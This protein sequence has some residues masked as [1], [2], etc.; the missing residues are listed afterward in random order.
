MKRILKNILDIFNRNKSKYIVGV[1]I[2]IS[3]WYEECWEEFEQT[4]NL[5]KSLD[6]FFSVAQYFKNNK[7]FY[8]IETDIPISKRKTH[9]ADGKYRIRDENKEKNIRTFVI[10]AVQANNDKKENETYLEYLKKK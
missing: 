9:S 8:D 4:K 3:D 10:E 2:M 5:N 1:E 7:G 6:H